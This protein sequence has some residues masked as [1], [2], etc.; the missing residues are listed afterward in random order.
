MR[1]GD[2]RKSQPS[3]DYRSV[4]HHQTLLRRLWIGAGVVFVVVVIVV[5]PVLLMRITKAPAEP[6]LA[7]VERQNVSAAASASAAL[8]PAQLMDVNFSTAGQV[9]AIYVHVRQEVT[10]GQLIAHL[11]DATQQATL[12]LANAAVSAA[13]QQLA[14][15]KAGGSS[16]AIASAKYQLASAR[17]LLVK[18]QHD[19]AETA[20]HAP[21]SATIL[22]VNNSVGDNV[23]G[24]NSGPPVPGGAAA[25][26]AFIVMGSATDYLAVAPFSQNDTHNLRVGQTG[27][28]V[29][30]PLPGNPL[31]CTVTS[32][33]PSPTLI[34]GVPEYYVE[35]AL[36]QRD[37]SLRDGYTGNLSID[38]ADATNVLA[39]PSQAIFTDASGSLQVDVWYQ[40][41]AYATTVTTGLVGST[42]TQITSGL[43]AGQQVVLAPA[44]QPLSQS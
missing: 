26:G 16:A 11:N 19:E 24:G 40:N 35:C 12:A 32:I 33:A 2:E 30:N 7:T 23:P 18:A 20:L 42:L 38:V 36:R 39:V 6:K 13:E 27:T 29:V 37:T 22:E 4:A 1:S 21:E 43:R 41:A 25:P 17:L 14:T 15:A 28:V 3:P 5:G 10:Q 8:Q 44:E 34:G 9:S 31:P